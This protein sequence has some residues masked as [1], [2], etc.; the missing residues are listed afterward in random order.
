MI[1][2]EPS[3]IRSIITGYYEGFAVA[4]SGSI[5]VSGLTGDA[6][7]KTGS[8]DLNVTY[9]STPQKGELDIKTGSGD[10][11]VFFPSAMKVLTDF[12]SGSGRIYNELG[13]FSKA[14]FKVSMKA[15]S[16]N[17]KIKKLQ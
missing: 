1:S 17:L 8:G 10:A 15:G 13:D 9:K 12:K 14:S 5:D 11:T 16:G 4:G 6:D 3:N 2:F 7:L